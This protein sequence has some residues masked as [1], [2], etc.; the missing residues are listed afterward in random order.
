MKFRSFLA[1][2]AAS[3]TLAALPSVAQAQ[4]ATGPEQQQPPQVVVVQPNANG[5]YPTPLA[6]QTQPSYVPQS[7][8]MS[9]PAHMDWDDERTPPPGYHLETRVRKGLVIAGAVTFGSMYILTALTAAAINDTSS[10]NAGVLYV[11]V[12]GP[13][14]YLGETGSQSGKVILVIDGLAQA[15]GA[16]MLITGLAAPKTIAVRNDL[17]KVN[18]TPVF[19]PGSV[20]VVGTF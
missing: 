1:L 15:A 10:G 18:I 7:I 16:A 5:Q 13:F 17:A 6:Q 9:G 19:G 4:S 3:L 2:T 11:P 20:G 14:M 12:A 8:A